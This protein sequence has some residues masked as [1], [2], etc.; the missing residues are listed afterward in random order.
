MPPC[1]CVPRSMHSGST[2]HGSA[3]AA[4]GNGG[5]LGRGDGW[6]EERRVLTQQLEEAEQQLACCQV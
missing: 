3:L 6:E 5:P 1:C 2:T 4:V